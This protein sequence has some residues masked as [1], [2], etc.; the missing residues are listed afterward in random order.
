MLSI[1]EDFTTSDPQ[2]KADTSAA[3]RGDISDVSSSDTAKQT[4]ISRHDIER[5]VVASGVGQHKSIQLHAKPGYRVYSPQAFGGERCSSRNQGHDRE[6]NNNCSI[7]S[8]CSIA[9]VLPSSA[10]N[11][12]TEVVESDVELLV[13]PG[14]KLRKLQEQS[15][16]IRKRCS[17]F[18]DTTANKFRKNQQLEKLITHYVIQLFP[19][20]EQK[21]SAARPGGDNGSLSSEDSTSNSVEARLLGRTKSNIRN[22][23]FFLKG[24]S[25]GRRKSAAQPPTDMDSSDT[26]T[27]KGPVSTMG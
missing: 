7:E 1:P 15:V 27:T 25:L 12:D 20:Q 9:P 22:S 24:P 26:K 3:T 19:P 10:M 4:R 5:L 6:S 8:R 23:C 11:I 21:A 16:H 17:P 18:N 2:A 13:Q 14:A